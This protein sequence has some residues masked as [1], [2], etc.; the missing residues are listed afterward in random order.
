MLRAMKSSLVVLLAAGDCDDI[1][2][3]LAIFV[4]KS[5]SIRF[6]CSKINLSP[7]SNLMPGSR[8]MHSAFNSVHNLHFGLV[9]S[10]RDFLDRHI[11]H[12]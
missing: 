5:P 11:S 12:Y 3:P 2:K 10:Q 7:A 8:Y 1:E 6:R 4:C 9:P